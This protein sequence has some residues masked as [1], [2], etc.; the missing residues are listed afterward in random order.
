MVSKY[1]SSAALFVSS[2]RDPL[3]FG[4]PTTSH[5]GQKELFMNDGAVWLYVYCDYKQAVASQAHVR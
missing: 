1:S 2:S 5:G 4:D 3:G